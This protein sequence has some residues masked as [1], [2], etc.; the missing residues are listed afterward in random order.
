[1]SVPAIAAALAREDLSAGERLVTF[2]LASFA[3]R[4]NRAWPGTPAAAARAGLSRSRYLQARDQ[5]VRRGLVVVEDAATGR[6]R[7]STV[8][9][10]FADD[11]PWSEREIN[12]PLFEAALTYSHARGP[13]RLLLATMAALASEERV[14]T[15]LTTEQLSSAAGLG[16]RS[17][18]R[19]RQALLASGELVLLSGAARRRARGRTARAR[20]ND[21]QPPHGSASGDAAGGVRVTGWPATAGESAFHGSAGEFVLRTE[22]HSEAHPMALL[23]QFLVAFGTAC[24]RGAHYTIEADHHYPNEFCVLATRSTSTGS[25]STTRRSI[26]W[27]STPPRSI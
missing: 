12:A 16:D 25:S 5:L 8:G 23:A 2:S 26:T 4:E 18:R 22:P 15:D 19:A 24:G 3:N 11:G 9:L 17:Y 13:A 10:R 27:R 14:M 21:R 1:M 6:G 7:S 20:G